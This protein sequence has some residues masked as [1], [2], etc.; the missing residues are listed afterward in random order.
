MFGCEITVDKY[1]AKT[2]SSASSKPVK[3]LWAVGTLDQLIRYRFKTLEQ[4]LVLQH[5]ERIWLCI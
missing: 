4:Q 1:N 2:E 3:T 5:M